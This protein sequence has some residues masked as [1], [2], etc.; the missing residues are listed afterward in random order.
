M[1]KLQHIGDPFA[2]RCPCRLAE[3]IAG[4]HYVHVHRYEVPPGRLDTF[5]SVAIRIGKDVLIHQDSANRAAAYLNSQL[6]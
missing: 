1:N 6:L 5:W 4:Y 2:Q 3:E